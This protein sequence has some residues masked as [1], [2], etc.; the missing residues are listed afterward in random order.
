MTNDV[1]LLAVQFRTG[2]LFDSAGR[3]QATNDPVHSAAPYFTLFGCASGNLAGVRADVSDDVAAQLMALAATEPPYVDPKGAPRHF[4][5]YRELL[6][7]AGYI[8]K[9]RLGITYIL[10]S[11]IAYEH[12]V[13]LV[14]SASDEGQ[15]LRNRLA[16]AGMPGA[17]KQMGFVDVAEFWEPWCVALHDGEIAA[18]AFAARLSELGAGLGLATVPT[19]RG[20]GYAAAATC[21]WTRMATLSSRALFYGT[22][23]ANT[24]SQRVIARL[25]LRFLG[26]SLVLS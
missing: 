21:G 12:D 25:G 15:H 2:F 1:N 16:S 14:D 8:S 26:S 13:R 9:A 7:Y 4:D 23:Q 5:R 3:M 17:L 19:L 6:A 20:R 22:D 10:P 24:S 11:N 18:V